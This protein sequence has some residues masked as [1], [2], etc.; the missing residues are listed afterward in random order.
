MQMYNAVQVPNVNLP[1]QKKTR[2]HTTRD[3][4]PK[5]HARARSRAL[6]EMNVISPPPPP[7]IVDLAATKIDLEKDAIF[8]GVANNTVGILNKGLEC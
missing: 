8:A 6:L 4:H 5:P 3:G 7:T 1:A 2:K